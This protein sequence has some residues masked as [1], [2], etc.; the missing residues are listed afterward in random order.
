MQTFISHALSP[1]ARN[2]ERTLYLLVLAEAITDLKTVGH[3]LKK[4]RVGNRGPDSCTHFQRHSVYI[5]VRKRKLFS[6]RCR[7][8]SD[9]LDEKPRGGHT[10]EGC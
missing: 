2:A 1:F 5:F 6:I 7:A 9:T 3:Y 10:Q 8:S 4:Y